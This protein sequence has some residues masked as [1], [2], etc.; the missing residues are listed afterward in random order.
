LIIH[1][2][3]I[4]ETA[5]AVKKKVVFFALVFAFLLMGGWVTL[6]SKGLAQVM[7]ETRD[8]PRFH[9]I[10][11]EV[12]GDVTVTQGKDQLLEIQ[13]DADIISR[14][15]TKVKNGTL[16]ISSV[17]NIR[18][19]LLLEIDIEME[20]IR[21]LSISGSGSI[22]ARNSIKANTVDLKVSGS[23]DI[24]LQVE[25]KNVSSKISGSGVIDLAGEVYNHT[26]DISGS[27]DVEAYD[28]ITEETSVKISGSGDC[29]VNVDENLEVTISGSGD[30]QYKGSPK[31]NFKGSGSGTVRSVD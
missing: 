18:R 21:G 3:Y 1:V 19:S 2:K 12:H 23:G 8:V 13:A 24:S 14:L 17:G 5:V 16:I 25:A 29:M 4:E 6:P 28:L 27:G 26:I 10:R 9:S 22:Q 15:R 31:V 20:E 7:S 11:L 30:V